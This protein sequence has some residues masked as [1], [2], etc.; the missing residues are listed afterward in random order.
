MYQHF[1]GVEFNLISS[2]EKKE[3]MNDPVKSGLEGRNRLEVQVDK[4]ERLWLRYED[5]GVAIVD[6]FVDISQ[7]LFVFVRERTDN[8]LV[9]AVLIRLTADFGMVPPNIKGQGY[10]TH[11]PIHA[12]HLSSSSSNEK[13]SLNHQR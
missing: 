3:S 5:V 10:E 9:F 13:L 11:T 2:K 1:R 4:E 8:R 7:D 6:Y 12:Q